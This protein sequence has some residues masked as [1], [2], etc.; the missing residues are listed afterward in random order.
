M[1]T[2]LDLLSA[3]SAKLLQENLAKL[4]DTAFDAIGAAWFA[5]NNKRN[6]LATEE[7]V[8]YANI[9]AFYNQ[10]DCVSS[11]DCV[12]D[13]CVNCCAGCA[14]DKTCEKCNGMGL[15]GSPDCKKC[16]GTIAY[17]IP[18]NSKK[19]P[20]YTDKSGAWVKE[21][22]NWRQLHD[23]CEKKEQEILS[24]MRVALFQ[25]SDKMDYIPENVK[26]YFSEVIEKLGGKLTDHPIYENWGGGDCVIT[27]LPKYPG[28][29]S[30]EN[31]SRDQQPSQ[32]SSS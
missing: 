3:S 11:C 26:R 27:Y 28:R 25:P 24:K 9:E 22:D 16:N 1:T 31:Q 19:T 23:E 2:L 21:Q 14:A 5:E 13:I 18:D 29:S 6:P 30:N 15:V 32:S 17:F 8:E 10:C 7:E 4:D 20:G 12:G